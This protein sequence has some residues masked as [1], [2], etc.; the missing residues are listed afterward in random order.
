MPKAVEAKI[1]H[2]LKRRELESHLEARCVLYAKKRGLMSRKMNGFGFRAWPDRLFLPENMA[3]P[4]AVAEPLLWVEFKRA[5][6]VATPEQARLHDD[7]RCRG[8]RVVVIDDYDVFK[9]TIEDY[10]GN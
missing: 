2:A 8:Q 5:G 4:W 3:A 7:L 10:L 9:D 6:Q 1:K